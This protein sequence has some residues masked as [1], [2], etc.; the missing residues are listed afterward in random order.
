VEVDPDD[1][2]L[3]TMLGNGDASTGLLAM[4]RTID[5]LPAHV[6]SALEA[7]VRAEEAAS[8]DDAAMGD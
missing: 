7:Q 1:L 4:I 2:D 5:A 6:R 3:L 8:D